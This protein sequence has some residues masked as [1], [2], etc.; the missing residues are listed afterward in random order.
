MKHSKQ[1]G[2]TFGNA[3]MFKT[4]IRILKHININVFYVFLTIFVVPV[5][6]IVSKGARLTYYYYHKKRQYGCFKS[7]WATFNNHRLF[8]QTVVDKF[9]MY[10]GHKF[11]MT[12]QGLE[13][14]KEKLKSDQ[15]CLMLSAH[16]GCS[17]IVGYTIKLPKPCNV[18][19]YGGEKQSLMAYRKASFGKMNVKMIPVGIGDSH[20]EEIINALDKGEVISAF[21]DRFM[22][23]NKMIVSTIHGHKVNLARGPFSLAITRGMDVYMVSAM[24]ENRGKYNVFFTP[25]HYDKNVSSSMQRQQL[26]DAYTTEIERLLDIYPMQWFNYS[27]IWNHNT[28]N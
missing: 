9:A 5:T 12:I 2:K 10:A 16:I 3:W 28:A 24:K 14:F 26:A 19:V 15:P 7:L 17:E 20:S 11:P 13:D 27:N 23:A 4:L 25:L 6:M 21:A 8:G 18:L 22:N 1:E